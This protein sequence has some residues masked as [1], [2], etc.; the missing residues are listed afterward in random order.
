MGTLSLDWKDWQWLHRSSRN[1]VYL[2]WFCQA[3]KWAR[4]Q[5]PQTEK[6]HVQMEV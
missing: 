2:N 6:Q 1:N 3:D 5:L 4:R